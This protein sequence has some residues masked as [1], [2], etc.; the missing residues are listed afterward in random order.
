LIFRIG[1]HQPPYISV[2]HLHLHV[3]APASRIDD[4]MLYK[5]IRRT[6]RFISVSVV[7]AAIKKGEKIISC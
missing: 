5:F 6:N 3:L 7:L 4:N 2:D 1:F